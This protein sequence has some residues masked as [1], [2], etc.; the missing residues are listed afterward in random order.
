MND[1]YPSVIS[2]FA[3]HFCHKSRLTVPHPFALQ[4][5]CK[6]GSEARSLVKMSG[7]GKAKQGHAFPGDFIA[8]GSKV[9]FPRLLQF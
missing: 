2:Q 3:M 6:T 5:E 8:L 9:V 4:R 1:Q 7:R